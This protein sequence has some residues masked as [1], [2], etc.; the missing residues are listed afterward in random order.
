[1][2][3]NKATLIGNVGKDPEIRTTQDGKEIANFPLATS[4]R[5]KDKNSGE[6]KEK[7]EWHRIVIFNPGLI[8]IVKSYVKKGSK[9]YLEGQIQTRKWSKD[10]V[11]HYQTEI[12]LPVFG[13][14]IQLL[15]SKPID[16]HSVAKGNAYVSESPAFESSSFDLIDDE[17]PF[18]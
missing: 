10:G 12:V 4:E 2:T 5:W 9:L 11:D 7:T 17:I 13:G 6:R 18:N 3:L 16:E 1:M 8:G 14:V 15:D